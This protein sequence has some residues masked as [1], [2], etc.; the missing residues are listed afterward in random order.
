VQ[1]PT[2]LSVV[3]ADARLHE[4]LFLIA[5]LCAHCWSVRREAIETLPCNGQK[6][7]MAR[8]AAIAI[9]SELLR[10]RGE[11]LALHF[12][13]DAGTTEA[14]L[15]EMGERSERD[16]DLR[17]TMRFLKSACAAVLGLG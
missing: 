2:E 7:R 8:M 6:V 9:A 3:S 15:N 1:K 12:G 5:D 4:R 10:T 13:G 11:R 17:I 14:A 16:Y